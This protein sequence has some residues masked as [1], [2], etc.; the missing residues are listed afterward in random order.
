MSSTGIWGG[1]ELFN[2]MV[3]NISNYMN[4]VVLLH[5]LFNLTVTAG[6][7]AKEENEASLKRTST[8]ADTI[9]V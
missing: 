3:V 5:F 8:M 9:Q 6:G 7:D 1:R 4:N 2:Q